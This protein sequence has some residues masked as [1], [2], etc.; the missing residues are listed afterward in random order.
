MRAD[1][2]SYRKWKFYSVSPRHHK[3]KF[4]LDRLAWLVVV[5]IRRAVR[6]L[7]QG[8]R[9][10]RFSGTQPRLGFSTGNCLPEAAVSINLDST[11]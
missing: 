3:R 7:A 5:G 10:N 4:F 11:I 6:R 8:G 1:T 9:I 2:V